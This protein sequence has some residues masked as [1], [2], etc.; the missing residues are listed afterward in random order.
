MGLTYIEA[1]I[2]N[3]A[4]SRKSEKVKFLVD[5]GAAYS[6]V[7]AAVLR[8]IGVKPR[9]RCRFIFADGSTVTRR[10]GEALFRF[11]HHEGTSS[12]IFGQ[13]GDSTLLG[14]V[15]LEVLGFIL[16]PLKREL[17]PL[18]MMLAPVRNAQPGILRS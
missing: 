8:R 9:S 12:V 7:P 10:M 2:A 14:S 17:R 1:S 6:V 4:R 5:S 18:P 16:D 15:S 11:N 13:R 3:P